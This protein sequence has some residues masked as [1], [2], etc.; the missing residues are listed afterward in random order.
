MSTND[1][2]HAMHQLRSRFGREARD[3]KRRLL[4]QAAGLDL[5]SAALIR[6]WHE[7]LLFMVTCPDDAD[8]A[9]RVSAELSRMGQVVERLN[10]S[11]P[12]LVDSGIAGSLRRFSPS[13]DLAAW[14]AR[15]F[16][17][18]VGI[19]WEN[20]PAVAKLEESLSLLAAVSERDGLTDD[21]LS[22]RQ[23]VDLAR[24][25]R[26]ADLD[27]I[28]R[29]FRQ[30][31]VGGEALDRLFEASE[32]EVLWRLREPVASRTLARLPGRR[33]FFQTDA[34]VRS[35]DVARILEQPLPAARPQ[36][37]R[38][39][40]AVLDVCRAALAV[41][42]RETDPVTHANPREVY[43][44][45]LPRGVDVVIIGMLPERRLP[46]ESFFGYVAARNG[47]PMAYGGGWVFLDRCEV[48][49][50]IFDTFRGGESAFIFAQILRVYRQLFRPRRF[51][52]DPFQFGA[53]NTEAIRSG[54][55]WFYDRM[56]FRP[57]DETLAALADAERE[58][59]QAARGYRSPAGVLR[60]LAGAKL[61]MTLGDA[62]DTHTP[63]LSEI[64]LGL[65]AWIG[66][67]FD[68]DRAAAVAW[69]RD[70]LARMLGAG[71]MERWPAK[72]RAAFERLAP[73]AAWSNEP[74]KWPKR[75]KEALVRVLRAKGGPSESRY[76]RLLSRHAE[77]AG[78]L[79]SLAAQGR[80]HLQ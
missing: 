5:R 15:R 17:G 36:G 23:W 78:L 22:T 11:R 25:R 16:G 76:A 45:A 37:T 13:L 28:V 33:V 1:I 71:G 74:A 60:R 7:L 53:G 66:Q 38:A 27:W 29:Q 12:I 18:D 10:G 59:M 47:V 64:A 19:D 14:M 49:I 31:G 77:F 50:N 20:E 68:G 73:L 9:A 8:I 54:A 21:R 46:I 2:V 65:T 70:R 43:R 52:V 30:I 40:D 32:L 55:F 80:K 72:Q 39:A 57:T 26:F 75:S 24:G 3:A 58:R 62:V 35:P 79:R 67:R 51:T 61:Q 69:S 6:Q 42:G 34:F 41:R 4:K 44:F 48:G 56:G 63:E